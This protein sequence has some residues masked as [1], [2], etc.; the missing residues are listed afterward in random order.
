MIWL[1]LI[2]VWAFAAALWYPFGDAAGRADESADEL[3]EKL[4]GHF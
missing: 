3:F 4:G 2:P 1:W